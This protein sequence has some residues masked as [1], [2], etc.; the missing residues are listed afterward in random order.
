MD[1]QQY[2]LTAADSEK[3]LT[4]TASGA[5]AER[6]GLADDALALARKGDSLA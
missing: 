3:V 2:A 1:I 5:K 4:D 6:P